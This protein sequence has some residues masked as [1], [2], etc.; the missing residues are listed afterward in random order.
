MSLTFDANLFWL[1]NVVVTFKVS[2]R[3]IADG[4]SN[5]AARF[6]MVPHRM[7]DRKLI[8]ALSEL[9]REGLIL[10]DLQDMSPVP[11]C[12]HEG[13]AI[14]K[15]DMIE[16]R[17]GGEIDFCYYLT[18]KGGAVWESFA[19]PDW[20]LFWD[21]WTLDDNHDGDEWTTIVI[22]SASSET[23]LRVIKW[24]EGMC[25]FDSWDQ[26]ALKTLIPWQATYWKSL[27]TGVSGTF[28]YKFSVS[29]CVHPFSTPSDVGVWCER[30]F[31][32]S[33]CRQLVS[34]PGE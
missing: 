34:I 28:R 19:V 20:R 30:G 18:A 7:D 4:S 1:L 17:N 12:I 23:L 8:D 31:H 27:P 6:H 29:N 24:H 13:V 14:T 21:E 25:T 2:L 16:I 26:R 15:N 11:V 33:Q 9:F 10:A 22:E 32:L 3:F 5:V